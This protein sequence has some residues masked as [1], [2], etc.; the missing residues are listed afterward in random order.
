MQFF[1]INKKVVLVDN[2]LYPRMYKYHTASEIEISPLNSTGLLILSLC[3]GTRDILNIVNYVSDF[4]DI[5]S[6]LIESDIREFLGKQIELDNVWMSDDKVF[7]EVPK[8]GRSDIIVPY[9]LSIE[10]TSKC[11]LKCKHCYNESGDKYYNE[12]DW[13]QIV[14]ILKQYENCGGVSVMLTGGEVFLKHGIVEIIDFACS[15]FLNVSIISNGYTIDEDI[16]RILTKWKKKIML[17][18]SLDGLEETH[19]EIRGVQGAFNKTIDNINE[20]IRR[21]V[22]VTIGYTINEFNKFDLEETIRYIKGLGCIGINLGTVSSI[23]RASTNKLDIDWN[24]EEFQ[25]LV[26]SLQK[27]YEDKQFKIVS[28]AEDK[29]ERKIYPNRCGAGYKIMHLFSDGRISLC[30]P[31]KCIAS[32]INL[33]DLKSDKL[34]EVLDVNNSKFVLELLSPSVEQCRHCDNENICA[35]CIVNMLQNAK[36]DCPIIR[37][38]Q[39]AK[40][41][42]CER[43]KAV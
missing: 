40:I 18:I 12:L 15:K 17:Q 5:D 42:N 16:F 1:R 33:G 10:V 28:N 31:S 36:D 25:K 7:M 13:R 27:K 38:L 41:I 19:D 3:D 26:L 14:D 6:E 35:G 9:L 8:K 29:Y 24:I 4:Y 32:K 34:L 23:G 43:E 22:H 37:S 2:Y 20:L 30:P 21:G 39:D 11:Q